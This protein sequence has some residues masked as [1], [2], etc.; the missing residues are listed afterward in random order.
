MTKVVVAHPAT[1]R[2]SPSVAVTRCMSDVTPSGIQWLWPGLLAKGKFSLIVGD[3]GQSKSTLISALTA[4]I[5]LGKLWPDDSECPRGSVILASAEDDPQDTIRPRLDA[6]GADPSRVHLLEHV[7]GVDGQREH[8][9]LGHVD[10]LDRLLSAVG[11]VQM[12][13]IDPISAYMPGVDTHRNSDVR[14][15]LAPLCAVAS[16]HRVALVAVSHLNK[17]S[18][19]AAIY[20]TTGSLGFVAAARA[21]L[22]V[23]TPEDQPDLRYLLPVKNNLA[24]MGSGISYRI[25]ATE[26]GVPY[27]EWIPG[28]IDMNADE[29]LTVSP[30]EEKSATRDCAKWLSVVLS[31]GPKP[32]KTVIAEAEELGFT[33]K[34][35]RRARERLGI[36][37]RKSDL[38]GGW[39]WELPG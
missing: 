5:T 10:E 21:C 27:V 35:L 19:G 32:A 34:V 24:P 31:S 36:D 8:F 2:P 38:R 23:A 4:H 17:G 26:A 14:S 3:P 12:V 33:T 39:I 37:P 30:T 29:V 28:V 11:D 7:L 6:A 9:G 16:K 25:C 13:S 22:L 20:R 1:A 15:L 18:G